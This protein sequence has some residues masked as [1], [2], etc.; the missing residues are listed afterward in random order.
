M[1]LQS[2]DK[3]DKVVEAL[4]QV[5]RNK[6]QYTIEGDQVNPKEFTTVSL[7]DGSTEY[8]D[9]EGNYFITKTPADALQGDFIASPLPPQASHN[10]GCALT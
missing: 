7:P 2:M 1:Q 6:S 4:N 3:P 9:I 10:L 5:K 8:Y